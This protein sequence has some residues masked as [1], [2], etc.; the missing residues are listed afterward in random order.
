MYF[1]SVDAL[2]YMDGHG[3]FVWSAYLIT[4]VVIAFTLLAPGRRRRQCLKRLAGE[5]RR[6]HA[7][8][9]AGG[10]K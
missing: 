1:Q 5:V 7:A 3:V 6:Q 4:A 9:V 10:V 8:D 2:L